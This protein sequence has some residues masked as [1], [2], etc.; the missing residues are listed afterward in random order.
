MLD[1][2]LEGGVKGIICVLNTEELWNCMPDPEHQTPA[3]PTSIVLVIAASL[4]HQHA[5]MVALFPQLD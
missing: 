4:H 2:F 1:V 3:R 5:S